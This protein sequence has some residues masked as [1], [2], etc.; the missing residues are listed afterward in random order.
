MR[1]EANRGDHSPGWTSE[2]IREMLSSTTSS[3]MRAAILVLASSGI[4][5]GGLELKWGDIDPIYLKDGKP[6]AGE[7]APEMSGTAEPVCAMMRVYRGSPEEYVTFM[8]PEAYKALV[9]YKAEWEEEVSR[10][11]ELKDPVFKKKGNKLIHLECGTISSRIRTILSK[12]GVR[13]LMEEK[14]K[15][16]RVPVSNG[17]RRRFNKVM[18][19]TSTD[20]TLGAFRKKEYMM[21][22]YGSMGMDRVYYH[23][24]PMELAAHYL[25]AVPALTVTNEGLLL[26]EREKMRKVKGEIAM[27]KRK[28]ETYAGTAERHDTDR[29]TISTSE[30]IENL[31]K[32]VDAVMKHLDSQD[33]GR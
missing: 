16:F 18:T 5:R 29:E 31:R 33:E 22:H 8:T 14:G 26:I 25:R 10:A 17:F 3:M 30:K 4:R 13:K 24:N 32:M 19:D 1:P 6:V 12:S 15:S 27:L 2:E 28:Q 21:G 11:P 7:D 20:D 23:A 9:E